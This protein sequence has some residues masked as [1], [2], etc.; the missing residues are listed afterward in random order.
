MAN[1]MWV[2]DDGLRAMNDDRLDLTEGPE[3]PD[4]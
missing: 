4:D 2:R 3:S 1:V